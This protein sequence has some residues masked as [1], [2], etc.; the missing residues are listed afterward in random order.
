MEVCE[1]G[2]DFQNPIWLCEYDGANIQERDSARKKG[3]VFEPRDNIMQGPGSVQEDGTNGKPPIVH[4]TLEE[5]EEAVPDAEYKLLSRSE[6]ARIWS[7]RE[8]RAHL[9]QNKLMQKHAPPHV[10]KRDAGHDDK[11]SDHEPLSPC[12]ENEA[13]WIGGFSDQRTSFCKRKTLLDQILNR[14]HRGNRGH[15]SGGEGEGK[16]SDWYCNGRVW[17]RA[18]AARSAHRLLNSATT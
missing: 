4:G 9:D 6:I 11:S 2:V 12:F 7:E 1:I 16:R 8:V 14:A 5:D 13:I 17:P 3:L 18:S 10:C 15:E